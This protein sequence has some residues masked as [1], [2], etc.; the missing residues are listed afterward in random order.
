MQKLREFCLNLQIPALWQVPVSDYTSFRIGGLA[1]ALIFP[2]TEEE[3]LLLLGYLSGEGIRFRV[4]GNASNVLVADEG[5]RGALVSTRHIRS[6]S[7][8][9]MAVRAAC[10]VPINVLCRKMAEASLGGLEN[11]YGIPGTV[12]GAIRMNASAFGCAVSDVLDFVTV[13]DFEESKT[14]VLFKKDCDF[15]YRHSIFSEKPSFII[16]S[17]TF[18]TPKKPSEQIRE[19][20]RRALSI[21]M[22]KHPS[23]LPSAGSVF[24]KHEGKSAGEL[25]EGA[26]LK[27]E[28]IGG[29]AVSLK[30]A[31]FI[32]NLGGATAKDVLDLMEYVKMRVREKYGVDL[33]AEIEHIKN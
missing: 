29:A 19:G 28:R 9:G 22:E 17:A 6:L 2:D 27:G 33:T 11:L 10:G 31:G 25:I 8:T 5:F 12:G 18:R 30:H 20:M 15:S 13:F 26:G 16:L 4:L 3:L 23:A 1:D 21:R 14:K 24:L 32:V 7:V